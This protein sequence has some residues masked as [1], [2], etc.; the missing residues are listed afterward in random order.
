M[1]AELIALKKEVG[2]LRSQHD[3]ELATLKRDLDLRSA[4]TAAQFEKRLEEVRWSTAGMHAVLPVC[5]RSF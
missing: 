1:E 4:N 2:D 3:E 5:P